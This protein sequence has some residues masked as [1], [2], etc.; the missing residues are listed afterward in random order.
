[1]TSCASA[2]RSR[3]ARRATTFRWWR[4]P[5]MSCCWPAQFHFDE[6]SAGRFLDVGA[7]VAAAPKDAHFYCCG[8]TA[9]LKAFEAATA[10]WPREQIHIEYFTAK[11]E[12]SK[13]GG[14]VVELARSGQEFV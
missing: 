7:I 5:A 1:M 9:M 4:T 2:G 3:S 13:T 11:Q 6:E 14:F 10:N 12:P 8:P